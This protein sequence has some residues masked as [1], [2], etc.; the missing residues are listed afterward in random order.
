[1][2]EDVSRE[3]IPLPVIYGLCHPETGELR[4]IGKANDPLARLKSHLRDA[5]RRRTPVYDWINTLPDLPELVII[6][7]CKS[8]ERWEDFERSSI[9]IAREMGFRLL[10]LA[11]GGDQPIQTS[12]QRANAGRKAVMAR[13]ATERSRKVWNLKRAIGQA[14]RRGYISEVWKERLR[15]HGRKNPLTWS[16]LALIK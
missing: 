3:T 14:L 10:N 6:Y 2:A 9:R 5:R 11:E 13:E 4:Y 15:E 16:S 12:E 7:Q 8:G 1:M